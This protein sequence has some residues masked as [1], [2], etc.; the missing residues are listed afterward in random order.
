MMVKKGLQRALLGA[1]LGVFISYTITILISLGW[2]DGRFY[3]VV[4]ELVAQT[5]SEINAVLVQFF[6]SAALGAVCGG[7]S[8]IW[9]IENWSIARQS[10]IYLAALSA[11]MF[12]T[13]YFSHWMEHSLKGVLLYAGVFFAL[14]A[15]L[16][17]G[18]YALA[19]RRITKINH[20]LKNGRP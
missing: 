11:A 13:A 20:C 10:G 14:F 7:I 16:W 6:L 9:M 12:P 1:P 18:G 15:V 8:V 3:P 19:K 2:G 17:A 4:P 5:G